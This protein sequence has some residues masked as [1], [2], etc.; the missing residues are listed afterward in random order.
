VADADQA[1]ALEHLQVLRNGLLAHREWRGELSHRRLA[2]REAYI[3]TV[4]VLIHDPHGVVPPEQ[5]VSFEAGLSQSV[6]VAG[7]SVRYLTRIP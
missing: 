7:R 3:E 5:R 2:S 1:G 6:S 4:V